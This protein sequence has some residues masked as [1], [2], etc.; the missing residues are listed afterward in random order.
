VFVIH[1]CIIN[2]AVSNTVL[3]WEKHATACYS[4]ILCNII[5]MR[6]IIVTFLQNVVINECWF[7]YMSRGWASVCVYVC[8]CVPFFTWTIVLVFVWG[9]VEAFTVVLD[10]LHRVSWRKS[11]KIH[12][13]L[14]L[15]IFLVT[16]TARRMVVWEI[17]TCALV[18]CC[19]LSIKCAKKTLELT[20]GNLFEDRDRI[21]N[22]KPFVYFS[23]LHRFY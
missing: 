11:S 16:D 17:N 21:I 1:K 15:K 22:V 20:A 12:S 13:D 19:I 9:S 14:Y 23:F 4:T 7:R 8:V 18:Q 6:G 5:S 2:C 3:D 10:C